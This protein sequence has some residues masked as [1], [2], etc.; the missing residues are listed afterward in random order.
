MNWSMSSSSSSASSAQRGMYESSNPASFIVWIK[1]PMTSQ[2][3]R[4]SKAT[5]SFASGALESRARQLWAS[6]SVSNPATMQSQTK[7]TSNPCCVGP[8]RI[9]LWC[10]SSPQSMRCT[11]TFETPSSASLAR[12]RS[13]RG[14]AP[15]QSVRTTRSAPSAAAAAPTKPMPEPSSTTW[16]PFRTSGF[17]QR[18]LMQL[19]AAGQA[20]DEVPWTK[21]GS[22][23]PRCSNINFLPSAGWSKVT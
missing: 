8:T 17:S 4:Y 13:K 21:P 9:S 3:S 12:F 16:R 6:L 19:T 5:K 1:L 23:E 18:I 15:S 2:S 10:A 7:T 14:I 11:S 20:T 22:E